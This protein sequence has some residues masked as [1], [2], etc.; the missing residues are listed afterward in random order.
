M[1]P[2]SIMVDKDTA[3]SLAKVEALIERN[4]HIEQDIS[5]WEDVDIIELDTGVWELTLNDEADQVLQFTSKEL[6][7]NELYAARGFT[8]SHPKGTNFQPEITIDSP[9]GKRRPPGPFASETPAE[10]LKR[11]RE[12]VERIGLPPV[13]PTPK[14][15]LGSRIAK[16]VRVIRLRLRL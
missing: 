13:T 14:A 7:L 6:T 3:S 10:T 1:L 12:I 8:K 16:L 11:S 9:K 2:K 15:T 4:P 5:K